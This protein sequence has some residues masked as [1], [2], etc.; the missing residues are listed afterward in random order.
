MTSP[1]SGRGAQH[2]LIFHRK[3]DLIDQEVGKGWKSV[4]THGE[5]ILLRLFSDKVGI[6]DTYVKR[7]ETNRVNELQ[8]EEKFDEYY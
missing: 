6:L 8:T 3:G 7:T 2:I 5:S 4:G 1:L